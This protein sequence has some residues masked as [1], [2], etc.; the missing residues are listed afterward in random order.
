M[1][2]ENLK[3]KTK[4]AILEREKDRMSKNADSGMKKGSKSAALQ[5]TNTKSDVLLLI[6]RN[7]TVSS[8][9]SKK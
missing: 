4:V 1:T 6:G 2:E 9:P 3:L 8:P 5:A 7:R